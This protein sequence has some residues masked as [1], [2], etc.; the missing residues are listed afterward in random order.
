MHRVLVTLLASVALAATAA[1][2][3]LGKGVEISATPF[4]KPSGPYAVG[5]RDYHWVDASRDEAL[6]KNPSDKRH[7]M[8]QVWYPADVSPGAAPNRYV[9]NPHE[10]TDTAEFKPVLH[11]TTNAAPDAPVAKAESKYPV[12][13]Y[14]HGGGWNRF[15]ATFAVEELASHGYVVVSV[16]HPGF[17]KIAAFPDGYRFAADTLQFKPTGNLKNDAPASWAWLDGVFVTWMKDATF[18]LDKIEEL[19]R[20][21][22]SP[23]RGRLDLDHIGALG[24]SFGG[25][26]AIE[27]SRADPRIKAAVDQDG[28]LFGAVRDVGTG[29]PYLQF[30]NTADM[31]AGQSPEN[32]EVMKKALARVKAWDQ[33]AKDKSTGDWYDLEIKGTTHGSFSDLTLFFP[34]GIGGPIEPQRAHEIINTYTLAF[35]DKYLRGKSSDLLKAPSPSFPE[36][37]FTRKP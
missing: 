33:A 22:G 16:E 21:L 26:A 12:L 35:F 28:Q 10:F 37:T 6:T 13:L 8:V 30:H 31:L 27:L 17:S 18:A 23:L 19:N 1:H 9:H 4:K 5:T 7:L 14:N 2:A 25:A 20:A 15:S 29:R 34:R 11:V 32:A 24:W 36:V 3:Q